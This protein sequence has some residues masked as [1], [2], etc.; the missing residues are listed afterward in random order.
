MQREIEREG[1]GREIDIELDRERET[2]RDR[3]RHTDRET[4]RGIYG[5]RER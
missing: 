4:D 2:Q 3:E 1:G 5:E